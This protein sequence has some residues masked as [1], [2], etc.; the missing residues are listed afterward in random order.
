MF[1]VNTI[2]LPLLFTAEESF[3]F[4]ADTLIHHNYYY[5]KLFI[6]DKSELTPSSR[7]PDV[8]FSKKDV[9]VC[10]VKHSKN[11]VKYEIYLYL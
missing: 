5:Q 9:T 3:A 2:L 4:G 6:C 8:S 7:G 1:R 11:T 10:I